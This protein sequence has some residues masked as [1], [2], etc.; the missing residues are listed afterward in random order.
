MNLRRIATA[1]AFSALACLTPS[2]FAGDEPFALKD[3]DRVVFYGDSITEQRLYTLYTEAYVVTR[4]PTLNVAFVHSGVGGDRVGGGWAGPIDLRLTRD[5]L[6]YK[7][8]VMTIMLGMNDG[9]YRAF[10]K[11]IFDTYEQGY[12]HIVTTMKEKAPGLRLT[13]VVPSPF[14]DVTR[15]PNFEGGYNAVL[16]RYGEFVRELAKQ[17]GANVADL[18]TP[19][20]EATKKAFQSDPELAQ[21]INP[22]RV[23]P[24]P[25]GQLLMAAALLKSWHAPALV[26]KVEIDVEDAGNFDEDD[27]ANAKVT[28][29]ASKDG[30]LVWTQTDAALPMPI[31]VKDP[32]TALAIRSSHVVDSLDKQILQVKGLDSDR[33]TLNIDG[34]QVGE[35]NRSELAGGV[36]LATLET[37]ML[38]Q[39]KHV[40][41]L[42]RR[43]NDLHFA[44]WRNIQMPAS[45]LNADTLKTA[46]AAIDAL[47]ADLVLKARAA[48]APVSHKFELKPKK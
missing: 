45:D 32:A 27:V 14:D 31:D 37:P 6:P 2:A 21:K 20:V 3:G 41:D 24:A 35:F 23:H 30:V 5:V 17:E 33:Y 29:L 19:V 26:S 28:E 48:A 42:L 13:L 12:R 46:L 39:S 10:D 36:N 25:A 43:H 1:A 4:F 18:N 44:R 9:S 11:K 47:E 40:L 34:K 38:A 16:T 7:P 15:K 8:T 22:D